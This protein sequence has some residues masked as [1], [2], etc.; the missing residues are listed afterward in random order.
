MKRKKRTMVVLDGGEG[1]G[2]TSVL[3]A[4]EKYFGSKIVVTR[5]P[6]GSPLAEEIREI[7]LNSKNAK[8]ADVNTMFALFWAARADH[9]KNTI[10]PAL[11]NGKI[12]ICDRFDS[13]TYAYQ[14]IAQKAESLDKLFWTIRAHFIGE[15][16]PD[17]YVYLDLDP[18]VGLARKNKQKDEKLNHFDKRGLEFHYSLRRGFKIFLTDPR[19][20]TESVIIDAEKSQEEV[21]EECKNIILSL[22]E[23]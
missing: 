5:E 15:A 12:V 16:K 11:N 14:I 18:K 13:S 20:K 6:G 21:F 3:K 17:V 23:K 19:L 1:A 2:K 22:V 8:Q 9:I 4:L 7:A 10:V